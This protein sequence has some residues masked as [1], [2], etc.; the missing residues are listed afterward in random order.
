M[1]YLIL[2][3]GRLKEIPR[4]ASAVLETRLVCRD[5]S[6]KVVA[7]YDPKRIQ[8]FG[9]SARMRGFGLGPTVDAPSEPTDDA[10]VR[11]RRQRP[12]RKP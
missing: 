5:E 3:N 2:A 12:R 8:M 11:T 4:A 10:G 6:G 7:T 9:T 1:V